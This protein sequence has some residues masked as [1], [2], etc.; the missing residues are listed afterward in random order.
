MPQP[1]VTELEPGVL[2][3]TMPLPWALDHVHRYALASA[4]GWTLVDTGLGIRQS[5]AW[6]ED[7]L[8]VL[9]RPTVGRTPHPIRP[10]AT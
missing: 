7:V 3:V 10:A 4:D 5:V 9:S 1:T 2:Q 8:E 6:W